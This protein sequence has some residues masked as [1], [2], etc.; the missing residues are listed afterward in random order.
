M[1][2]ERITT[3]NQTAVDQS[4]AELP[5]P[6][7]R[8][9]YANAREV[10]PPDLLAAVQQHFSGGTLYIPPREAGYYAD[11]RKLVLALRLQGVPTAEIANMA[12]VTPRRVRQ[13]LAQAKINEKNERRRRQF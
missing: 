8:R 13:I 1:E 2:Q 6:P 12:C 3:M 5:Q 9:T 10:L 11:R 4:K 7:E